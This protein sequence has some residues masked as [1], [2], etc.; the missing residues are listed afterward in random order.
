MR[1]RLFLLLVG[2]LILTAGADR[3]ASLHLKSQ[4]MTA[5]AAANV[6]PL[7]IEEEEYA[8]YSALIN[9]DLKESDG[10]GKSRDKND[11]VLIIDDRPSLWDGEIP[12]EQSQFFEELKKSA[13]ELEPETINDLIV[14]SNVVTTLERKFNIKIKYAL[15]S[16]EEIDA[17]FK[18]GAGG[19]EAFHKKFPKSNGILTLSRVGFNAE[20][21]QALVYKGWSCGGLCGGGGYTLLTKKKGVWVVGR[22]V[23][24]EWVS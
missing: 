12:G 15:V 23:G 22:G 9:D 4:S 6:L 13:P 10:D 1:Y 14:K 11:R 19:W 8:V 3:W 17:L 18:E 20:K 21:T 24:P 2:L 16:D 5:L 7:Q